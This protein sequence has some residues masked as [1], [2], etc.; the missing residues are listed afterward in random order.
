M[1]TGHQ[2][3]IDAHNIAK[4]NRINIL[5]G[6]HYSTEKF[7]CIKMIEY[8]QKLGIPGEFVHDSPCMEDM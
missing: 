3:S 8:F 1:K 4:A 6:T 5:A 7:A 2:P